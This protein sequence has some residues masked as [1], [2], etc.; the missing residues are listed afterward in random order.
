GLAMRRLLLLPLAALG[1]TVST[2][3]QSTEEF[4]VLKTTPATTPAAQA[5][6]NV[7]A[8]IEPV[9]PAPQATTRPAN[10]YPITPEAGTW[11]ICAATYLGPDGP[12]LSAQVAKQL[13]ENHRLAAYIFN[14][15]DEERQKQEEEFQALQ[16][17]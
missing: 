17:R 13:R 6:R 16:K 8:G 7:P 1:V 2:Y 11:M 4:G 9:R 5:P 14:R 10:P 12:T 3:A 15:G